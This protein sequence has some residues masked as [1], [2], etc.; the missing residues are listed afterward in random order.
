MDYPLADSE[1]DEWKNEMVMARELAKELRMKPSYFRNDHDVDP[2]YPY[3]GWLYRPFKNGDHSNLFRELNSD[4]VDD[5]CRDSNGDKRM[6]TMMMMANLTM[7]RT[8]MA[9]KRMVAMLVAVA[10]GGEWGWGRGEA[11]R[12]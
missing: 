2:D 6:V 8:E 9:R 1:I 3:K 12:G 7:T 10:T 5:C 11:R 4:E